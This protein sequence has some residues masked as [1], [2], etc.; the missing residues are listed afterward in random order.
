MKKL[1]AMLL[2]MVMVF[3]LAACGSSNTPAATEAAPAAPAAPAAT[4]APAADDAA[5]TNDSTWGLTPFAET[6]KL[7]I[8]FFTGSPLSY[9]Y[10]FAENL[11]VFD[12]LNI[13]TEFVCF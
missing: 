13:D 10:L 12:A 11:G 6:Q 4:E 1:I 3:S 7:R 5:A 8:G 2:A 9:P